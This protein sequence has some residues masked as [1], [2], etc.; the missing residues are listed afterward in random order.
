MDGIVRTQTVD[1]V[2]LRKRP[3][4]PAAAVDYAT[5]FFRVA[6]GHGRPA[7]LLPSS[8]LCVG[9]ESFPKLGILEQTL[10]GPGHGSVVAR[11]DEDP[12]LALLD[13]LG[14]T[15]NPRQPL[16]P[17]NTAPRTVARQS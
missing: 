6:S 9:A 3:R 15:A 16:R 5:E 2:R 14:H 11:L 10:N 12:A 8:L 4:P 1:S 7:E 13:G 17:A